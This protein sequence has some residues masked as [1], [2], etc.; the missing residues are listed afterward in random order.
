MAI[1]TMERI[2]L[3][4]DWLLLLVLGVGGGTVFCGG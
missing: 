1:T 2:E 4:E 3:R